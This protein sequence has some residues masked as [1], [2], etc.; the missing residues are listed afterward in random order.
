[1]VSKIARSINIAV[2]VAVLGFEKSY[3]AGETIDSI[4][5]YVDRLT[6]LPNRGALSVTARALTT[7]T[8]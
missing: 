1:M 2:Q 6:G 7:D 5:G 4:L 8:P 3:K